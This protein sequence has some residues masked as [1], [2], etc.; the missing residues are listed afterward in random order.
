[1]AGKGL[2]RPPGKLP[3]SERLRKFAGPGRGAY[4]VFLAR[5]RAAFLAEAERVEA[6]RLA[7]ALPPFLPPFLEDTVVFFLP[8]PEP[9]FL[10]PPDA[11]FRFCFTV[12]A[13]LSP[14]AITWSS[15]KVP[16]PGAVTGTA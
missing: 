6:G 9:L 10:P 8:P 5:V 1:R 16:P 3:K 14:R 7:D 12:D 13:D 11:F 2:R 4:F 15:K